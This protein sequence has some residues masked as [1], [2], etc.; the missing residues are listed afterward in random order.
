MKPYMLIKLLN[1][2]KVDI[3]LKQSKYILGCLLWAA[4][5]SDGPIQAAKHV[6]VD[7]A[8]K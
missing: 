6:Q 8:I 5:G 4:S 1:V 2:E 3:T 7:D